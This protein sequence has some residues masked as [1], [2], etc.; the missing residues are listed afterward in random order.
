MT[1]RAETV[2]HLISMAFDPSLDRAMETALRHKIAWLGK[3]NGLSPE[4]DYSLCSLI[5]D[6]RV[7]QT[8]NGSKGVHALLATAIVDP[9]P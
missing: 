7:T 6:F 9:R 4:D 1:P 3:R 5:A 2:T 8:V